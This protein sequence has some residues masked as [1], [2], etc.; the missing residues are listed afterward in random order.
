MHQKQT[1]IRIDWDGIGCLALIVLPL[2]AIFT[3]AFFELG[4]TF[5]YRIREV[6]EGFPQE[7]QGTFNARPGRY[8]RYNETGI[9]HGGFYQC[10]PLK[11]NN[12]EYLY[13]VKGNRRRTYSTPY[14]VMSTDKGVYYIHGFTSPSD[15]TYIIYNG[16]IHVNG[17]LIGS[18]D[19][20]ANAVK[21]EVCPSEPK[22]LVVKSRFIWQEQ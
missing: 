9:Y 2:L 1:K 8:L 16:V 3:I 17:A 18:T 14:T 19:S 10:G 13:E 12:F 21:I 11:I 22:Q 15:G 6:P 7:L 4:Y 20:Y 5:G